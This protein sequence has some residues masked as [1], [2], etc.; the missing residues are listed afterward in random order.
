MPPDERIKNLGGK[1]MGMKGKRGTGK[2]S[3]GKATWKQKAVF[4]LA[5]V[6]AVVAACFASKFVSMTAY[7][8]WSES[9]FF[10]VLLGFGAV[11]ELL[12]A[13]LTGNMK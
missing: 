2:M 6:P 9:V 1:K 5:L 13:K 11:T 4:I 12:V 3:T 8:R 7:S 10:L